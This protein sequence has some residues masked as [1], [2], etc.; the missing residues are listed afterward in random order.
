MHGKMDLIQ[1]EWPE[2]ARRFPPLK[3]EF[4]Q[5]G[6]M[7]P[8]ITF[9]PLPDNTIA[10]PAETAAEI[11]AACYQWTIYANPTPLPNWDIRG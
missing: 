5:Q 9:R 7:S 11:E 10:A 1:H 6:I 4:Q 8:S 3:H 2:R